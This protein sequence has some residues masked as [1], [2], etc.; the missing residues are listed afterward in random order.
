[1][2]CEGQKDSKFCSGESTVL[3][4]PKPPTPLPAGHPHR[5]AGMPVPRKTSAGVLGFEVPLCA[6]KALCSQETRAMSTPCPFQP[7][8]P[9][10]AEEDPEER[11]LT[12][13]SCPQGVFLGHL[14]SAKEGWCGGG[15]ARQA[16]RLRGSDSLLLGRSGVCSWGEQLIDS[17][18]VKCSGQCLA[19]REYKAVADS[20]TAISRPCPRNAAALLAHNTLRCQAVYVFVFRVYYHLGV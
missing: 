10:R 20:L 17:N 2:Q 11:W 14:Q 6:Q 13:N 15:E 9:E 16:V 1:M 8:V 4:L 7:E 12:S 5:D 18:L 19:V 3:S